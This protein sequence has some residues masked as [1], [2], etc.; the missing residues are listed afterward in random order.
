MT[1]NVNTL[2]HRRAEWLKKSKMD[3]YAAKKRLTADLKTH[4]LKVMG[5]AKIFPANVNKKKAGV[6]LH[7]KQNR[8]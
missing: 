1:L 8:L 6:A 3:P 4:R 2:Q 5:W 7:I